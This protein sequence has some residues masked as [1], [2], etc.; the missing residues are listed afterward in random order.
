MESA[1]LGSGA[2]VCPYAI[3]SDSVHV[4]QFALLNY[5]TSLGHDA[6]VGAFAVLS[7]YATLGGASMIEADTFLGLHASIAPGRSVACRSQVSTGAAVM[8]DVPEGSLAY[9]VPARVA[10]RLENAK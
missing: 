9:G 7:P 6:A 10:P 8:H 2:V 3:V 1:T 4:G 5:H